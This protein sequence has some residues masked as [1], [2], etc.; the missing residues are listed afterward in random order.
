MMEDKLLEK[1]K[2]SDKY[3]KGSSYIFPNGKYLNLTENVDELKNQKESFKVYTHRSLDTWLVENNYSDEFIHDSFV[4]LFNCVKINDGTNFT[5][6]QAHMALP[7]EKLTSEQYKT[8]EEWLYHTM[9]V[10]GNSQVELQGQTFTQIF[11]FTDPSDDEGVFP[12]DIIKW[13]KKYYILKEQDMNRN[14]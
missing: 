4:H 5:Y 8:L 11:I 9:T 12:E 7:E 13:I 2:F 3:T 6:Q 10:E 14:S 1:F